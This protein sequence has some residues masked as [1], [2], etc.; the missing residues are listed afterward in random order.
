MEVIYKKVPHKIGYPVMQR[1]PTALEHIRLI[2]QDVLAHIDSDKEV[3]KIWTKGHSMLALAVM[4]STELLSISKN[5]NIKIQ[6]CDVDHK[7]SHS[8]DIFYYSNED[9]NIII[10]DQFATGKTLR[11]L[12]RLINGTYTKCD[13]LILFYVAYYHIDENEI[14]Q[15]ITDIINPDVFITTSERFN[16]NKP[17]YG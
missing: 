6:I 17:V 5:P 1:I 3:I 13:M 8:D 10:D 11:E 12:R 9:Y 4:L 7:S 14:I 15:F 16:P 2:A